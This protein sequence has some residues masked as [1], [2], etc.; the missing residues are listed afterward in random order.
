MSLFDRLKRFFGSSNGRS[1]PAAASREREGTGA[2]M[3]GDMISCEEALGF[4]HEFLDG[5]L[6]GVTQ[7]RVEAH[8]NA[9]QRCY[10]HLHLE[11]TF[12]TA[13]RRAAAGEESPPEL[14][15]R[16]R[17]LIREAENQE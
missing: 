2:M 9:C 4:I 17:K 13:V 14:R 5:E 15:D 3:S 8:F 12:R 11:E 16:V 10:P 7:E 6:E 1:G